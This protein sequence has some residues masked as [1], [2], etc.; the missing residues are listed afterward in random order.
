MAGEAP[1]VNSAS[2]ERA[3]SGAASEERV[4]GRSKRVRWKDSAVG[5]SEQDGVPAPAPET[6]L[7]AAAGDTR[8]APPT[9]P[10]TATRSETARDRHMAELA[11]LRAQLLGMH[12]DFKLHRHLP[13]DGVLARFRQ[14]PCVRS[15]SKCLA[16]ESFVLHCRARWR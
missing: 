6:R 12:Q 13:A 11:G 14:F 4:A 1:S 2:T 15:R 10:Q 5:L 3:Y 8:S 9:T 16:G 7:P